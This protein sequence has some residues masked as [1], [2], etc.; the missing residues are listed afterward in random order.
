MEDWTNKL[1]Y[2]QAMDKYAAMK[3]NKLLVRE[4]TDEFQKYYT[5]WKCIVYD[6][7]Y[8]KF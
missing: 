2:S 8:M 7:M 4:T 3:S 6:S 1:W 5:E